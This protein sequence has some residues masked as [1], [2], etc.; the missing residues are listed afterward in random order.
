MQRK[1]LTVVSGHEQGYW[2]SEVSHPY[3]H[4]TAAGFTVDIAAPAG[5]TPQFSPWS[6]PNNEQGGEFG[7]ELSLKFLADHEATAKTDQPFSISDVAVGDYDAVYVAGGTGPVHDLNGNP[8]LSRL[9]GEFWDR[10]KHVA[11]LCHGV[12]ALADVVANGR[13]LIA[14]QPVT[15]YSLAEDKETEEMLG[16]KIVP[17]YVEDALRE[18]GGDYRA[19]SP[20]AVFVVSAYD[21]RLLT[22]QNQQ[23]ASAFGERLAETLVATAV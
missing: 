17:V 22:A 6:D 20:G 16:M 23:S 15:G 11:A 3:H 13:R 9:L 12:I 1:V 8:V 10:G 14:G 18:A 21:G 4:L 19:E 7:D 5:S 2:L